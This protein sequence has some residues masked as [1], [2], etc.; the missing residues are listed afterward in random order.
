MRHAKPSDILEAVRRPKRRVTRL[1]ATVLLAAVAASA[2][3][4][5]WVEWRLQQAL[6]HVEAARASA[7]S[8][9]VPGDILGVTP[10]QIPF[11]VVDWTPPISLSEN[12]HYYL[13]RV[14]IANDGVTTLHTEVDAHGLQLSGTRLIEHGALIGDRMPTFSV[15]VR[16]ERALAFPGPVQGPPRETFKNGCLVVAVHKLPPGRSEQILIP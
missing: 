3:H 4:W 9:I 7:V 11:V 12:A 1:M 6:T 15:F 5:A 14:D 16:F 10:P 13:V 8:S 2:M